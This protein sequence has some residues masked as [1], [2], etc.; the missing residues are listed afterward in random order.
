[1]TGCNEG[2]KFAKEVKESPIHVITGP[3]LRVPSRSSSRYDVAY[4]NA[5]LLQKAGIQVAIRTQEIENV[6]NLPYNAGFAATYGMGKEEALKAIT[7]VPAQIFGVADQLGS[8][9]EGKNATVFVSDG[10][11]F[12]TRTQ[13]EHLFIDGWKVSTESR[14]TRL[15]EEF[16]ERTPGIKK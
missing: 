5:G 3:V 9:E 11:P 14:H 2:W 15:Y 6:R 7:I 13:I 8:I 1:M 12:E 16:L 10:D 4:K